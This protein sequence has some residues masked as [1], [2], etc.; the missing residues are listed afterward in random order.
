MLSHLNNGEPNIDV[1]PQ[2]APE[3]SIVTDTVVVV[4]VVINYLNSMFSNTYPNV[5][6]TSY[7]GYHHIYQHRIQ[8]YHSYCFSSLISILLLWYI[9][10]LIY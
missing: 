9:G 2:N 1:L 3:S 6:E 4:V 10:K 5:V 8:W 7:F